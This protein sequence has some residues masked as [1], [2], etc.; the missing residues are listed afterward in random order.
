MGSHSYLAANAVILSITVWLSAHLGRRTGI[1]RLF[2][3]VRRLDACGDRRRFGDETF[4]G[5]E[6]RARRW[7]MSRFPNNGQ[8]FNTSP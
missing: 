2:L 4:G 1:F 6:R 7:R 3:A 8:I 5:R